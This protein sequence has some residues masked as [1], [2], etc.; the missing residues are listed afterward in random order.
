MQIWDFRPL[1]WSGIVF[2]L[3]VICKKINKAYKKTG[4][5]GEAEVKVITR[6][7][8]KKNAFLAIFLFSYDPTFLAAIFCEIPY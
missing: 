8:R 3:C 4:V 2:V 1:F 6:A 5:G 7:E